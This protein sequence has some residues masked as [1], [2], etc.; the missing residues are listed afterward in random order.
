[1]REYV[2]YINGI[3]HVVQMRP[4]TARKLG[5]AAVEDETAKAAPKPA[6]K[7]RT[8]RNKGSR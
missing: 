3:R 7:A 4:E 5:L 2:Q 6:N 1:M 8:P